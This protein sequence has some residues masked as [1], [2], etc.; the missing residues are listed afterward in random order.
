MHTLKMRIES[1]IRHDNPAF[2]FSYDWISLSSERFLT[3]LLDICSA[4]ILEGPSTYK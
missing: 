1:S 4:R 3:Y 2:L